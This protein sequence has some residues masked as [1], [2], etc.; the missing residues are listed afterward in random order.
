[1]TTR[2]GDMTTSQGWIALTQS[3][4]IMGNTL[5]DVSRILTERGAELLGLVPLASVNWVSVD[6]SLETGVRSPTL[7]RVT[8]FDMDEGRE[9]L[10]GFTRPFCAG[11]H[12][13]VT[14]DVQDFLNRH[15][16][17]NSR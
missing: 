6:L 7:E 15:F 10:N 8:D 1:M 9:V 14:E 4:H 11:T 13:P 3:G 2:A 5:Q 16:T 17:A 12:I